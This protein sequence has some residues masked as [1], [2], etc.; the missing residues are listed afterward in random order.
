MFGS[1]QQRDEED[2][3]A[4]IYI[5]IQRV[6]THTEQSE[7]ERVSQR[8]H[9]CKVGWGRKYYGGRGASGVG[10]SHVRVSFVVIL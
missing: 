8:V 1:F 3:V 10:H 9:E 7:S 2:V 5:H 6:W 4:L